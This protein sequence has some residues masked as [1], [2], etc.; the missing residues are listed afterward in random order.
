METASAPTSA[1]VSAPTPA[2]VRVA[3]DVPAGTELEVR[4]LD[5]LSSGTARVEDR[6]EAAT[7]TD[8]L[9]GGR[10]VIPAGALMRGFVTAV[11]PGSRTNRTA[12]LTVIFDQV[13]VDAIAHPIRA[14][15]VDAIKGAGVKGEAGRLGVGA[16]VGAIIG[17]ILGGGKGAVAGI[18]IGGG[19]TMAATEGKDVQL[20]QGTVLRVRFDAPAML[21]R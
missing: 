5:S 4:L 7:L 13:T 12:R 14:T 11:E 10:V 19:G 6:F 8:L 1:P 20:E 15:V 17:G 2:D 21:G 3:A 9:V 18:L 16:G